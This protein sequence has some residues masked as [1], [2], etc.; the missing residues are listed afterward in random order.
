MDRF[1]SVNKNVFSVTVSSYAMMALYA[2]LLNMVGELLPSIIDEF[3]LS[4]TQGGL[5]Q[6]FFNIGGISALLAL[7]Y[8]SDKLRKSRLV[9]LSFLLVSI[10]LFVMGLFTESYAFLGFSFAI[11]GGFTKVFDVSVNAFVNDINTTGREFYLQFLHVTF[12]LGAVL[13]PVYASYMIASHSWKTA[14]WVLGAAYGVMLVISI[15]TMLKP[16]REVECNHGKTKRESIRLLHLLGNPQIWIMTV[17]AA[18][19]SGSY[20]G[21]VTWFP[22]YA[23]TISADFGLLSGLVLSLF[24]LGFVISRALASIILTLRNARFLIVITALIGGLSYLAAFMITQPW[25]F[26]VFII[27]AGFFSGSTLP[28]IIFVACSIFPNNTGG[29][30]TILYLGISVSAM[31]IPFIMGAIGD[32]SGIASAMPVTAYLLFVSAISSLFLKKRID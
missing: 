15:R 28:M 30:T 20:V 25:A 4:L 17:G 11:L 3:N 7:L 16:C 22:S 24:F 2:V 10:V 9:Y 23:E 13:G 31:L 26:F 14:A 21:F 29:V 8:F 12:G 1:K 18:C 32:S 6:T 19:F 27:M 5:L